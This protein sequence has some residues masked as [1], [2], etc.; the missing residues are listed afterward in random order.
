LLLIRPA[1]VVG[2]LGFMK[3]RTIMITGATGTTVL[4]GG[5]NDRCPVYDDTWTWG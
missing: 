4:F 2:R 5:L 3:P 1:T